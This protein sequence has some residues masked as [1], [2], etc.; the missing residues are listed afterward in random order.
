MITYCNA[1]SKENEFEIFYASHHLIEQRFIT[2]HF[3][4]IENG[5]Y[6]AKLA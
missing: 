2:I 5:F 4:Q 1:V 3:R 6:Y